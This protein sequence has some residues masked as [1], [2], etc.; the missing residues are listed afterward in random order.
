MVGFCVH[1]MPIEYFILH[2]HRIKTI[3]NV[4]TQINFQHWNEF[5]KIRNTKINLQAFCSNSQK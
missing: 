4:S 2:L 5:A 3:D 1:Y